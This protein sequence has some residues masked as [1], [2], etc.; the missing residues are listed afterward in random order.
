MPKIAGIEAAPA[1][2]AA[3]QA[4]AA[5]HAGGGALVLVVDDE[6]LVRA[7]TR[8]SLERVGYQVITASDGAEAILRF[9]ERAGEVKV[10][11]LDM[12][13][14]VMGGA[15]CFRR[16]RE[17]APDLPVL[18]ASG[19]ALEQE[20]RECLAAGALGF[21]EKP[22]PTARLLEVMAR[23]RAGGGAAERRAEA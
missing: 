2:Q 14:P 17:V 15:E 13:M 16:L 5:V 21:L 22:F 8:R 7:V 18:L 11:V 4:P 12:A 6:P 9:Q 19:Y 3:P 23:A 10:V 1:A 20:A